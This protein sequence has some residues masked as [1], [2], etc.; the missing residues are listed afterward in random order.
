MRDASTATPPISTSRQVAKPNAAWDRSP[1]VTGCSTSLARGPHTPIVV[2][3]EVRSLS[4]APGGRWVVN[5]LL[6][7]NAGPPAGAHPEVLGTQPH[8]REVGHEPAVGVQQR[9]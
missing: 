9:G 3:G 8:H 6:L 1:R 7:P 5:P 4:G 2:Q